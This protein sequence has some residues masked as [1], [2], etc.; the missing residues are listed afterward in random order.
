MFIIFKNNI[1][2]IFIF[3]TIAISLA[4]LPQI[5]VLADILAPDSNNLTIALDIGTINSIIEDHYGYLWFGTTYNLV[6]YDGIE[7]ITYEYSCY[8][9]NSIQDLVFSVSKLKT[10]VYG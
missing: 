5:T 4:S 9:S 8:D 2:S 7:T 1:F 3:I 10:E 6:R